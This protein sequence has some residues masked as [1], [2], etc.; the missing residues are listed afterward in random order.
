[1][2]LPGWCRADI[3]VRAGCAP[4][5]ID[6]LRWRRCSE[7]GSCCWQCD[8]VDERKFGLG[9]LAGEILRQDSGRKWEGKRTGETAQDGEREDV[10]DDRE[11][12]TRPCVERSP[13]ASDIVAE[14]RHGIFNGGDSDRRIDEYDP[15]YLIP[16]R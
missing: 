6:H 1:M 3:R 13:K 8:A 5:G 10:V 4:L 14:G 7:D 16:Y 11:M 2:L 9:L 12:V 15:F